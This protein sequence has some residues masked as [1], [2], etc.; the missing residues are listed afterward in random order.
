MKRKHEIGVGALL[1]GAV[2]A[3]AWMS[4]QVGAIRGPGES[5]SVTARFEDAGALKVG[6]GVS[7]AGVD[8]GRVASLAVD[9]DHAIVELSL[10]A[11]AEV[12]EDA[13]ATIRSR[14]VLGEKYID[15]EPVSTSAPLLTDGGVLV[16]TRVERE[17][18][19]L[20]DDVGSVM[21]TL[22]TEALS[23]LVQALTKG[24]EDD[25]DRMA[26]MLDDLE[27]TLRQARDAAEDAP[28]L[29]REARAMIAET[30]A[31]L[32]DVRPAAERAEALVVKLDEGLDPALGELG[33]VVEETRAA[34]SD[35]RA[36]MAVL[37]DREDQLVQ[38]LD[39]LSEIDKWE[40]R[41]LL[42][43]EGILVRLKKS[44]V[45]PEPR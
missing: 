9:F 7:I 40:L 11:E 35:A 27:A 26:R 10:D 36:A 14:S 41:R 13:V 25:P 33:L 12:R 21:G 3:L 32:R 6:A 43:E 8:I 37:R 15:V 16:G 2:A 31:V 1:L 38:I 19:R 39:N 20:A 18:T 34:V 42:R 22:D 45:E 24:L 44:E 5:V 23:A 17:V 29:T 30:R 4:L 28:A